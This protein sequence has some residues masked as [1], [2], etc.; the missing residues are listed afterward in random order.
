MQQEA[1]ILSTKS[2]RLPQQR[3]GCGQTR[4]S[5]RMDQQQWLVLLDLL[6]GLLDL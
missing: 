5:A 1:P 4:F 2:Y 6:P 3:Q